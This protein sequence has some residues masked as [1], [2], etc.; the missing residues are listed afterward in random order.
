MPS[1]AI[2]GF[3]KS[4]VSADSLRATASDSRL[5][6]IKTST[7]NDFLHAALAAYVAAWD[8]YLNTVVKEFI[9][10]TSSPLDVEYSGIHARYADFANRSLEKFNTPNS[11][12]SRVL[13]IQCTGY[14]PI[15][16][17]IWQRANMNGLQVR[18]FLDQILKVRHSFAHGFPIPSYDWTVT[19]TGK[20]QLSASSIDKVRSFLTHLVSVTDKGLW[21]HGRAQFPSKH[22]W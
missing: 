3:R 6:P 10:K 20:R 18:D 21:G 13:L 19:P 15:G 17:W 5:R 7:K 11:N 22:N 9:D 12:N 2:S 4:V 1:V 8:S 14:D 16:D